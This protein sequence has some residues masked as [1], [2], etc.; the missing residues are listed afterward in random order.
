[1]VDI[2]IGQIDRSYSGISTKHRGPGYLDLAVDLMTGQLGRGWEAKYS[3]GI[4]TNTCIPYT[5]WV[6]PYV[7]PK[8]PESRYD[9]GLL[10]LWGKCLESIKLNE[11]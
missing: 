1:M 9:T 10:V 5:F 11:I 7:W 3:Y 8:G 4:N 2:E 6:W